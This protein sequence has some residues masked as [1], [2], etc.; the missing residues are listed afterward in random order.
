MIRYF[1]VSIMALGLCGPVAAQD[2]TLGDIR[3]ELTV[4]FV[5]V[6]KLKRELSTTGGA[7]G[8]VIAGGP[9][10]RLNTIEAELQ[11]LTGKTEELEF[12]IGSVVNDG[13]NRIGDLE[14][15]L[16]ELEAG[17]DVAALG[18]T[19]TLG[20]GETPAAPAV[21]P[22]P[23]PETQLA[24][25]EQAD[26]ER[27][28][29]ALA[30]RDFRAAA[31]QFATFN[32]TYPGG[33]LSVEAELRRGEALEGLGDVREGAR[34]YL[35]AF[36]LDQQGPVAPEALFRLGAAL[37]RLGQTSEACVTLAEVG[38]RFPASPSV[39]DAQDAMRN[40]GCS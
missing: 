23:Q 17:C 32:Q 3:Q 25:Q 6:Q 24:T 11:R 18:D 16:C 22:N 19:P 13:T 34:A 14:F 12:R 4:L 31:D 8:A 30:T 27:A 33:P 20:G 5:E 40:I 36:T 37:G 38:A 28:Q 10:D 1:A 9:L 7:S 26:F 15:R 21:T 2:Q 35:S 39:A 29:E